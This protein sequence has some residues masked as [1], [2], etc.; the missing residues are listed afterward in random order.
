MRTPALA[1]LFGAALLVPNAAFAD[2]PMPP[3]Q[4]PDF[5]LAPL[6]DDLIDFTVETFTLDNGLR[7]AVVPDDASPTVAIAVYYD[8]GSR[9]EEE[10]RSGF[11][12]LFEHMMFQGS[13]NVGKGEHFQ[14]IARN[15][16]SMNGTTSEDRTNYFEILPSDRLEL[17]LWLES[18]RMRSLEVTE[19]NFENQREVVKEERRLRVDNQPWVPGWLDFYVQAYDGEGPYGHSVIGS[20]ADLDAAEV[21]DVQAFF[22]LYYAPNNA[23]LV[24]AGDVT[25]AQAEPLVERW[26]GDIPR[27][28]APPPVVIERP[29][30]DGPTYLE[31]DDHHATA[32][33]AIL[34]WIV[35]QAPGAEN[36]AA[37]ILAE[38]LGSGE[39]SRLYD[40]MVRT[41]ATALD[42]SASIDGRRGPDLFM[43]YAIAAGDTPATE[44][45]DAVLDE[46][47]RL[48]T[49]GVTE[50]DIDAA[51]RRIV[52]QQVERVEGNLGRAIRV[53]RDFLYYDE[54]D[55]VNGLVARLNA[56]TPNDVQA[57]LDA[58]LVD[59][60]LTV[61]HIEPIADEDAEDT[62]ASEGGE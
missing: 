5:V 54:P 25:R 36:D 49:E 45:R 24:L 3:E 52:R 62:D 17:G 56:V 22:D 11:A 43:A 33:A 23:I 47:E 53:A 50:D 46:V 1:A 10:G 16:G 20:M 15:G 34:G 19:E 32:A 18:D 55:R 26:F 58:Y 21:E 61:M 38:I 29:E 41:D 12:H 37:R 35:P 2:E 7:V 8:V 14:Y 30:R 59:D 48:R 40:R 27:G 51:R 31:T 13:A 39:S 28:N 9:N 60:N 44:L 42:V 4:R 6:A 57:V